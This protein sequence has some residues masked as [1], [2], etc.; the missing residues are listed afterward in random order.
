M[1]RIQPEA[2]LLTACVVNLV[3]DVVD[4]PDVD[5]L[6]DARDRQLGLL[7]NFDVVDFDVRNGRLKLGRP[8]DEKISA[9][10]QPR[11]EQLN[12]GLVHGLRV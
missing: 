12:E 3:R 7:G 8:V 4:Q 9:V 1:V 2:Q 10:D 5:G 6:F 11:V